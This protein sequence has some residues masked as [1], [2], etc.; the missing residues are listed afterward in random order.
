LPAI[1][2]KYLCY[3]RAVT[4]ETLTLLSERANPKTMRADP[5][6]EVYAKVMQKFMGISKAFPQKNYLF[7]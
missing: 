3:A 1:K 4:D 5:T 6:L 7:I 2:T